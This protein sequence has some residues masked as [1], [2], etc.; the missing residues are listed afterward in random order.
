ML[1][2][3]LLRDHV[4]TSTAVRCL[5]IMVFWWSFRRLYSH[6]F[7]WLYWVLSKLYRAKT[8]TFS[9]TGEQS[10][11]SFF[12]V[13]YHSSSFLRSKA[14]LLGPWIRKGR[15]TRWIWKEMMKRRRD[16]RRG[17]EG[18]CNTG[19]SINNMWTC[20]FNEV[21]ETDSKTLLAGYLG[22]FVAYFTQPELRSSWT[23]SKAVIAARQGEFWY[24]CFAS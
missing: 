9:R 10:K 17:K 11:G 23:V 24:Q 21:K 5:L 22:G 20:I 4:S 12:R 8:V 14:S 2:R 6:R 1:G 19:A 3:R 7:F 13:F 15:K 16:E 18:A